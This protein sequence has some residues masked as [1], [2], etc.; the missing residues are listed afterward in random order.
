MSGKK[1][2]GSNS[3][4]ATYYVDLSKSG[5]LNVKCLSY[6]V[7][8]LPPPPRLCVQMSHP[9]KGPIWHPGHGQALHGS[10]FYY[11][12]DHSLAW[13][14]GSPECLRTSC[15]SLG[16]TWLTSGLGEASVENVALSPRPQRHSRWGPSH[17]LTLTN[18]CMGRVGVSRLVSREPESAVRN[19]VA[20]HADGGGGWLLGW[21]REA[22]CTLRSRTVAGRTLSP[23]S[24]EPCL[25]ARPRANCFNWCRG[26][27][28]L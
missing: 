18:T 22:A 24:A 15:R 1:A 12:D 10:N 11:N 21:K 25:L 17:R 19:L 4:T 13:A 8:S 26:C 27:R 20:T 23:P 7:E 5:Y 3:A 16:L 14:S 2:L 9:V 28:C 6:K